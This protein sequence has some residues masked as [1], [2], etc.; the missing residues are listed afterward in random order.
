M[1]PTF[2]SVDEILTGVP[3]QLKAVEQYFHIIQCLLFM[4]A[5]QRDSIS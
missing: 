5:V 1:V 3:M 4:T 2:Q